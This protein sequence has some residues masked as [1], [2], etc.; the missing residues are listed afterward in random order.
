MFTHKIE[1]IGYA[2][3]EAH[4]YPVQRDYVLARLVNPGKTPWQIVEI[5]K[6]QGYSEKDFVEHLIFADE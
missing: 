4:V 2:L 5:L 6:A 3:K 1:T